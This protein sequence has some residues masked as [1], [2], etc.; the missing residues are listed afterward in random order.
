MSLI[1][2]DTYVYSVY[3]PSE[4]RIQDFSLVSLKLLN[5]DIL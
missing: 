1:E 2:I 5:K 4:K 3:I